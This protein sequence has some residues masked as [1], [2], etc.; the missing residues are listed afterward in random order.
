LTVDE[1]NF[2]LGTLFVITNLNGWA[3]DKSVPLN[4]ASQTLGKSA[5][6]GAIAVHLGTGLF[7]V[8]AIGAILTI[9]TA[10]PRALVAQR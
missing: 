6:V 3:G 2:K 1:R 9:G 8:S 4:R 5:P 10:Q 7:A